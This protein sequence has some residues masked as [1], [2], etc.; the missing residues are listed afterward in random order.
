[1]EHQDRFTDAEAFYR[2]VLG[3]KP[4]DFVALNNLAFLLALRG[5]ADEAAGFIDTC[6]TAVG[7]GG[8]VLDTRA[9][10][11]L[12]QGKIE[13]AEKDVQ[14]ALR[15]GKTPYR[16][17]HLAQIHRAAGEAKKA[18]QVLDEAL[19]LGLRPEIMHPLERENYQILLREHHQASKKTL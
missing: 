15:Q 2:K 12:K 19:R 13:D 8:E 3:R 16:L 10:V 1:K 5:Q 17:F 18:N 9:V 6:I 11:R 4:G 14:E 7:P